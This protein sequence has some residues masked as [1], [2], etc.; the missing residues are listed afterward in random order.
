MRLAPVLEERRAA[1]ERHINSLRFFAVNHLRQGNVSYLKCL[2]CVLPLVVLWSLATP[3]MAVFDG[4]SQSDAAAAA[5]RGEFASPL[6]ATP[7]GKQE[8]VQVPGK[9][10]ALLHVADCLVAGNNTLP[11]QCS[12]APKASNHL[13]AQTTAANRYPPL[14]YFLD[15]WPTLIWSGLGAYWGLCMAAAMVN[16]VL[17]ALGLWSLI[18]YAPSRAAVLGWLVAVTPEALYLAGSPNDSGFEIAA[19][20]ATWST[21]LPLAAMER[22]PRRLVVLSA[23]STCTLMLARPASPVW[24]VVTVALTAI[25]AGRQRILGYLRRPDIWIA[26][27]AIV[28]AGLLAIAFRQTVG[29]PTLLHSVTTQH[30]TGTSGAIAEAMAHDPAM[31]VGQVG[32]FLITMV[33]LPSL[34]LWIAA[35]A[36]LAVGGF[37]AA[38]RRIAAAAVALGLVVVFGPVLANAIE[39]NTLGLWW[40]AR[41]GMPYGVG[42]PILLAM[43]IPN[44]ALASGPGRRLG[45]FALASAGTLQVVAFVGV[46]HRYAAGVSRSWNP[47]TYRWQPPGGALGISVLFL[48][49][50][51]LMIALASRALRPGRG[52]TNKPSRAPRQHWPAPEPT[53]AAPSGIGR[54][55]GWDTATG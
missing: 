37:A 4:P 55:D 36:I 6:V 27:A 15:G 16:S 48:L 33:P 29:T 22:P 3:V 45:R 35:F 39:I 32:V 9:L 12:P 34:L 13:V 30:A 28:S 31:L 46:L 10:A 2:A 54:G 51:A 18:E 53:L 52:H 47:S 23:V 43:V 24:V 20:V 49:A 42:L 41:D 25:V 5:V 14:Y 44:P 8:S 17:L 11:T 50:T 21:L 19:A 40:Q 1:L 26:M 38:S 7:G